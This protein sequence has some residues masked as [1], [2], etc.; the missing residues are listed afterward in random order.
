MT[1]ELNSNV[2]PN[3]AVKTKQAVKVQGDKIMVAAPAVLQKPSTP[4]APKAV[5]EKIEKPTLDRGWKEVAD[6]KKEAELKE[7]MKTEDPRKVP[8]PSIKPR[9]NAEQ[10]VTGVSPAAPATGIP[11]AATANPP[12]ATHQ[13]GTAAP[14]AS[15]PAPQRGKEKGLNPSP[16]ATAAAPSKPALAPAATV[17]EKQKKGRLAKPTPGSSGP[18]AT[19]PSK[20][21]EPPSS[22]T[23]SPDGTPFHEGAVRD[24]QTKHDKRA[25][26]NADII[27]STRQP[28]DAATERPSRK[29]KAEPPLAPP[30]REMPPDRQPKRVPPPERPERAAPSNQEAPPEA[31]G[32]HQMPPQ[33]VPPPPQAPPGNVPP[34]PEASHKG[35]GE[36]KSNEPAPTP[37]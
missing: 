30:N 26:K 6:P 11:P 19:A 34:K 32:K 5:K 31:H 14:A 3:T 9:G 7:K 22:L 23:T 27:R 1:V 15:V 17:P 8:P 13:L 36:K 33:R 10:P 12:N 37:H 2:D 29:P 21:Q 24:T 18:E 20:R 4:V 16:M 35:G 28:N 25:E